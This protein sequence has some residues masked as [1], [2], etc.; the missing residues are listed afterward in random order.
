MPKGGLIAAC[1]DQDQGDK[2]WFVYTDGLYFSPDGGAHTTKVL[3][4]AG[5]EPPPPPAPDVLP[6]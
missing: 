2:W 5:R 3:D 6:R 1:G 4:E